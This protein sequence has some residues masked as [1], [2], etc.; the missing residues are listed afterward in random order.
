M[1]NKYAAFFLA[2]SLTSLTAC[3]SFSETEPESTSS[4]ETVY[5]MTTT[6]PLLQITD[7]ETP[8]PTTTV[9]S[10]STVSETCSHTTSHTGLAEFPS[11]AVTTVSEIILSTTLQSQAET[12]ASHHAPTNHATSFVHTSVP[13]HT[14]GAR[15]IASSTAASTTTQTETETS[16]APV[17]GETKLTNG[18]IVADYGTNHP[19]AI[20]QF[21]NNNKVSTRYAQTLEQ[22]KASLSENVNVW[23]MVVP[24]SQAFYTPEDYQSPN[25]DQ[26][27]EY[28]NVTDHLDSVTGIP[29]FETLESHKDEAIYSRTDYHWQPLAAY[30]AG[31][32]FAAFAGVPY[33]PLDTYDAVTREG[34]VGAFSKVN[35]VSVLEDYPEEF[36]YYKPANLDQVECTYYN[37]AF[38]NAHSGSMFHEDNSINASYTV[39]VGTDECILE[40]DTNV[41]NS[42]VLVIFKDSYGNALVPFLTQSFS[43]IYLCD[44]RYFD[45]NAIDFLDEVGATDVLFAM[46]T[47]AVTTSGKVDQVASLM[48]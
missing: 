7:P 17:T 30:Y 27:A 8:A 25:S 40:T 14:T 5:V 6:Q 10:A 31:E 2:L 20:E 48:N 16:I 37:T 34:Y 44:F 38:S 11:T 12:S 47:V 32:Q 43:K 3:G 26:L 18:I 46:S 19:R 15:T 45:R 23:C 36:T 9:T 13:M 4:A 21:T 1:K 35:K 39:F 22:F 29:V 41:D 24:T 33:A 28:R 42:R